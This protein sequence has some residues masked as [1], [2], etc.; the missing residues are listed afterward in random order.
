MQCVCGHAGTRGG[1]GAWRRVFKSKTIHIETLQTHNQIP[2]LLDARHDG[3]G[4]RAACCGRRPQLRLVR[5]QARRRSGACRDPANDAS[6]GSGD[7]RD[8]GRPSHGNPPFPFAPIPQRPHENSTTRPTTPRS[9]PSSCAWAG[10]G[11]SP[12]S[13]GWPPPPSS[14]SGSAS[15][16]S[17]RR[18]NAEQEAPSSPRCHPPWPPRP[19]K[20]RPRRTTPSAAATGTAC[21]ATAPS[22]PRCPPPARRRGHRRRCARPG[23]YMV[24]L[25]K[26]RRGE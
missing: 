20:G 17:R 22:P 13:P 5:H 21:R 25:G 10:H 3:I 15:R 19:T 4:G 24:S 2:P 9:T 26:R 6:I 11:T 7:R 18:G 8:Q 1:W 12:A 16:A 14:S 23:S